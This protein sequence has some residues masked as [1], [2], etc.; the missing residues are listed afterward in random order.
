[1]KKNLD[2]STALPTL[3]R[4]DWPQN[5]NDEN[6]IATKI[7]S[8]VS[9]NA[10][11]EY[12]AWAAVEADAN[13][14]SIPCFTGLGLVMLLTPDLNHRTTWDGSELRATPCHRY[15][16][17]LLLRNSSCKFAA[18]NQVE[19]ETRVAPG[20]VM[21]C[22]QG[23]SSSAYNLMDPTHTGNHAGALMWL[24]AR[25]LSLMSHSIQVSKH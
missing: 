3:W 1:M 15:R 21:R 12:R 23:F 16:L 5:N 11:D 24:Y 9:L 14:H 17:A 13:Q 7:A 22:K 18:F 4:G 10:A 25:P 8:I 19:D 20:C 2:Q 6:I